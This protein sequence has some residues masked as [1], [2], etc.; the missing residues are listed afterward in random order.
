MQRVEKLLQLSRIPSLFFFP[1][2]APPSLCPASPIQVEYGVISQAGYAFSVIHSSLSAVVINFKRLRSGFLLCLLLQYPLSSCRCYLSVSAPVCSCVR[3]CT[4][5]L[6]PLPVAW[7]PFSP[8]FLHLMPT[9]SFEPNQAPSRWQ[10][11]VPRLF[12]FH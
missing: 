4:V 5:R 6:P 10:L 9:E 7:F 11:N 8:M 1:I 12:M 3:T 2:H